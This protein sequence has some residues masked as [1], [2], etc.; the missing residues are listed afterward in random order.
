MMS[1]A[2]LRV[3]GLSRFGGRFIVRRWRQFCGLGRFMMFRLFVW[4]AE[5]PGATLLP[6]VV[7]MMFA[8]AALRVAWFAMAAMFPLLTA[9]TVIQLAQGAAQRFDLAFVRELLALG[10][11][12]EFQNFF[13]LIHRVLERFDDLHH[14][15][16]RLMD[17]RGAMLRLGAAHALG[18]ILYAFQQWPDRLRRGARGQRFIGRGG[19]RRGCD[20]SGCHGSV[21]RLSRRTGAA[22]FGGRKLG[23][24][25]SGSRGILLARRL[26]GRLAAAPTPATS[27]PTAVAASGCGFVAGRLETA[28]LWLFTR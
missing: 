23:F 19:S 28:G 21:G 20:R 25:R 6:L 17:G 11:F 10:H 24:L 22:D 3:A 27:A 5:I 16:N 1:T 9:G 2:L 14:F 13:H 8:G 7:V 18:Q 4:F 12:D 26:A 15:I